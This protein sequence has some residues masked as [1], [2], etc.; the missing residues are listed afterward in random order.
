MVY[1]PSGFGDNARHAWNA[2]ATASLG[3][4]RIEAG[5]SKEPSG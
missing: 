1:L 2:G 4:A 5:R 3:I